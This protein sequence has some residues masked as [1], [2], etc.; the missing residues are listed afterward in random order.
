MAKPIKS[1]HLQNNDY[2]LYPRTADVLV[3]DR[4]G[5]NL[6]DKLDAINEQIDQLEN[7][8]FGDTDFSKYIT[9][10][11]LSQEISNR[12][13]DILTRKTAED[14]SYTNDN[15]KDV[16]NIA[17]AIDYLLVNNNS[18]IVFD[19]DK[20][21]NK[22][23][24]ANKLELTSSALI[25]KSDNDSMSSVPLMEDNDIDNIIKEL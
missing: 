15:L 1:C 3:I 18:N 2:I 5:V 16:T 22:P 21:N 23:Q 17:E 4:N 14:I 24:I 12:V 10:E 9:K 11:E 25:L 8:A 7:A 19:W 6:K 20:I 13:D